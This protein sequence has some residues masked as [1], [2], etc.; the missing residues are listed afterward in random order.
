MSETDLPEDEHA[1]DVSYDLKSA[2]EAAEY[3]R[4]SEA[5]VWRYVAQ[6]MVPAYRLGK[7]R[8]WFK[9]SDLDKL[10]EPLKGSGQRKERPMNTNYKAIATFPMETGV[11]GSW[12]ALDRA[13]DLRERITERR[14]GVVFSDSTEIINAARE[15]RTREMADREL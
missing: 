7:K 10:L 14:R 11:R 13:A 4:V 2:K 9:R 12:D 3:L 15:L 6:D 8:V 1:N 5:T